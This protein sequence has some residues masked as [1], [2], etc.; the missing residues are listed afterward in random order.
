MYLDGGQVPARYQIA[1][2]RMNF[3]Q[4]ILQQEETSFLYSML[5]AQEES[6]TKGDWFSETQKNI[7]EFELN[8][9]NSEIKAMS[10]DQF[11]KITKMKTEKLAWN[12]LREKQ[13]RGNKRKYIEYAD[14]LQMADYLH[15]N[16]I[17]NL[18]D[19]ILIFQIRSETNP[20]SSNHGEPGPC[21]MKCGNILENPHILMCRILNQE[22]QTEYILFLN[23]NLNQLK[24]NL[25]KWRRN[26]EKMEEQI[27]L[28]SLF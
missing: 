1:R 25:A 18:E 15:P 6:P 16:R 21:P 20:L 3:L 19:Q 11:H 12:N 5:R 8:L 23:G 27:A 7:R 4:Y 14:Q 26:V 28:D 9:S 13:K 22:V 2:F 17:L 24:L 10:K